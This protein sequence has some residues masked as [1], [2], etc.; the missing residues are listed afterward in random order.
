MRILRSFHLL[1]VGTL[2]FTGCTSDKPTIEWD[3]STLQFITS[4]SYARVKSV[5]DHHALV[6]DVN[7]KAHIRFS[8]DGCESWQPPIVV[9][10]ND[11]YIYTN[12]ELLQL[13]NG[14]LLYMWN[15]RPRK[16]TNLPFKIMY[17]IS[18]DRGKSWGEQRDLYIGGVEFQNGCWEPI[19]LQLA[20]GELQIYFANEAPYTQS[21]EQEISLMRSK[22][23]GQTWSKA[24][25]VSFRA[26]RRD[27]MA[28]PI[29]LPH[30]N[31]IAVAIEDNG[32]RGRFKPVI[33]R[34]KDNWADGYVAGDD[35]RREEAISKECEIHDTVYAGAPYLIRLGDKY[36][37]LSVQSASGRKGRNERYAN[38]QV[39]VGDRD[40]RNFSNCSTPCPELSIDENALWNSITQI[41]DDTII[42]VMNMRRQEPAQSGIWTIKGR[43]VKGK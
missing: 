26:N 6:Y 25:R 35:L 5:D 32:I 31:E 33:V 13:Q 14:N 23:N 2:L 27:G 41:D 10:H 12:C 9:A 15:A 43:V 7:R 29:Y 38:M 17:S 40:A 18:T 16:D 21:S 22:D 34:T 37:L 30:T 42:A 36:T 19:A 20:D 24:E 11:N 1:L 3:S 4:G 8:Y 39:Y 28:S